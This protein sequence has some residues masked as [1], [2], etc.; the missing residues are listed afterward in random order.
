MLIAS[1]LVARCIDLVTLLVLARLLSP[2]DFG[3][4]AI[5]MSVIM[6]T[7]A[8]LELPLWQALVRLPMTRPHLDTAF[9]LGLLRSLVVVLI[10]FAIAWPA[11]R[12]YGEDRLIPLICALAF[13]PASRSLGSAGMIEYA[14][15]LDFSREFV[16][17]FTGK[18]VAFIISVSLAWWTRSYWSLAAG[19]IAAPITMVI[20][21]YLLAPYRPML[22]LQKWRAFASYLGWSSASQAVNAFNWQIDQL[23][24][25]RLVSPIELGRFSMAANLAILPSQVIVSRVQSPLMVAFSHIRKD[26]H[27]LT[28]AYQNSATTMVAAGIP[29]M[30]GTSMVSEPLVRLILGGQWVEAAPILRWL[31]LAAIPIFFFA[32]LVPL[33]MALNRAKI[34]LRLTLLELVFKLPIVVVGAVYYGV[35]GI[36]VARLATALFVGGCS[37]LA[38]RRL[39]GLPLHTQ[40]LEAWRPILSGLAMALAIMPMA[41]WLANVQ[42]VLPLMLGLSAVVFVAAVVYGGSIFILWRLVG[43]PEGFEAKIANVL[44]SYKRRV[45]ADR[46]P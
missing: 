34:F 1:R 41:D 3:L 44:G 24:L 33:S 2:A 38:V 37:A 43:C 36:V 16:L 25:G 12:I 46:S 6:I 17:E 27:R 28:R 42:G 7:E 9:T 39:I 21:S 32:P 19:T 40:I 35:A 8:V 45:R 26:R 10:L 11:A 18:I 4:V 20:L 22:T 29:L 31:S 13:A 15:N 5:A 30:V 14:K 23:L